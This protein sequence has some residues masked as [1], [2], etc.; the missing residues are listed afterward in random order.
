MLH[1]LGSNYLAQYQ[2]RYGSTKLLKVD[3]SQSTGLH[4]LQNKPFPSSSRKD[5]PQDSTQKLNVFCLFALAS[6]YRTA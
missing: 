5:F 3:L 4:A 2:V 1:S 6:Y